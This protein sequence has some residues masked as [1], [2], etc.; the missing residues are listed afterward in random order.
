MWVAD[1][2]GPANPAREAQ[3]MRVEADAVDHTHNLQS[4]SPACAIADRDV[5]PIAPAPR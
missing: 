3:T 5:I 2:G 4:R 1:A